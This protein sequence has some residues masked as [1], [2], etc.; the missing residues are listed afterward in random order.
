MLYFKNIHVKLIQGKSS[1][2]LA[3]YYELDMLV[4]FHLLACKQ[5]SLLELGNSSD[6]DSQQLQYFDIQLIKH[7]PSDSDRVDVH[8][9]GIGRSS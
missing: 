9:R 4:D 2:K 5:G 1:F 7:I 6:I 3:R 8:S